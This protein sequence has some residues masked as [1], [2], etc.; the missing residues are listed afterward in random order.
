MMASRP[1]ARRMASMVPPGSVALV[2]G[3][4]RRL[5]R[6]IALRLARGGCRV[7]VHY[8]ESRAEAGAVVRAIRAAG[9]E[10]RAFPAD[11]S[12]PAAP[13]A[14]VPAVEPAL[15]PLAL[16]VNNAAAFPEN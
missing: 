1:A 7:A 13:A 6:A 8:G 2:T 9:G 10:A 15:R 14:L 5:G 3:A 4:A 16:L 12:R 11:L